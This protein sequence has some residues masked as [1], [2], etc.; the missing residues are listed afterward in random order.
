MMMMM[1][2]M[3]LVYN[4]IFEKRVN[5]SRDEYPRVHIFVES[6]VCRNDPYLSLVTERA[7]II[8]Q[9]LLN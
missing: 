6:N 3:S 9:S 5:V 1:M 7:T 4:K 8:E 2:M